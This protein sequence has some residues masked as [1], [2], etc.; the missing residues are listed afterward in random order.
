MS[1]TAQTQLVFVLW[2]ENGRIGIV[3]VSSSAEPSSN[4]S[5]MVK[6]LEKHRRCIIAESNCMQRPLNSGI[7]IGN[8]I[9]GG[10]GISTKT[11]IAPN[12]HGMDI[13]CEIWRR[14]INLGN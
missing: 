14:P 1:K 7:L 2:R 10:Q 4:W 3:E 11:L 9:A 13:K 6:R 12:H 8:W 5:M